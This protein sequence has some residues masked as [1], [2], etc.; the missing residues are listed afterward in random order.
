MSGSID[1]AFLLAFL[2]GDADAFG[3]GEI[4]TRADVDG[5]GDEAEDGERAGEERGVV[6]AVLEFLE[7]ELLPLLVELVGGSNE[8][9]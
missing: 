3:V 7:L 5:E 8:R 2:A 6:S 4:E 1:F 9:E